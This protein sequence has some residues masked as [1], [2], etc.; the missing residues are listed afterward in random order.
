[1]GMQIAISP[2]ERF[3]A[4][5]QDS[6]F[7]IKKLKIPIFQLWDRTTGKCVFAVEESEHNIETLVF[8]PDSKTVAYAES[9]NIVK[10]LDVENGS[11]QYTIKAA[12][13]FQTLAFSPDGSLLA[14]GSTDGIVRCWKVDNHGKQSISDRVRN[15]VGKPVPHKML[16]GHAANTKFTAIDF[17]PDGKKVVSANSDGTV[18]L[19]N[20]D[21]GKQQVTL[22]Q[23]SESQTALA[24]NA[25]NPSNVHDSSNRTL[26]SVGT[27]NSHYFVSI[28]DIDTGN[29]LSF[30]RIEKGHHMYY[31]ITVS[32]DGSLFVTNERVVR[33][34]DT[35]TISVLS[36]IGGNE[37]ESIGAQL[38]FSP[39][40]KRLAVTA[41]KDNTIQIW[42]MPNRKTLCR[43][44]G[45]TTY[46]YSLAFSPDNKSI[47]TSG[48][49]GKDVT[50]R[51]WDTM[52]GEMLASFPNQGA[53]AFAPDGNTFVGGTHVY[54][55]NPETI[56][57]NPTVR[58]E[59]V[60]KSN[61]PTALT[62]SPDGS[63]I[64]SG[65]RDGIIRLRDSTTGKIIFNLPGHINWISQFI[66]SEDGTTLATSGA[67]GTILLRDWDEVLKEVAGE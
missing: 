4:A 37:Y 60:S 21:T 65:N 22:T 35:Q 19:W 41:R 51:L 26:T 3:L 28:W 20:G 62:Y 30:D 16:K 58:L 13:P 59:D 38:V 7:W 36:A 6:R 54:A 40:G 27:S 29:R 23:H 61:P 55:L 39:D 56:Q 14:S 44:K 15:F 32:P 1:M 47:V 11:L 25:I 64:V 17:S 46:V 63:I 12:V 18:R 48:W 34:W 24:F 50:I 49:T 5:A 52:T 67:D 10:I 9:S 33:L 2:D 66:F 45:H 43:L 8:S 57:Y 53:V 42:D 31:G